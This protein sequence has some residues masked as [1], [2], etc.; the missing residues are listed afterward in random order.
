MTLQY[1][2]TYENFNG[3]VFHIMG[4]AKEHTD[5]VNSREGEWLELRSGRRVTYDR[6]T[7]I[8]SVPYREDMNTL[9]RK[10]GED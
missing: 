7:K 2:Q 1:W 10:L 3:E 4:P 6:N 9:I 8:F 5:F